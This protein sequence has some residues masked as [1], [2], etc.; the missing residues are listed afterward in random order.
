MERWDDI[1]FRNRNT[2]YGAYAHRK[3]YSKGVITG[4][5]IVVL[6][7]V[8]ISIWALY[9]YTD[10]TSYA[11]GGTSQYEVKMNT[12]P[13]QP[14]PNKLLIPQTGGSPKK[15][16][17]NVQPVVAKDPERDFDLTQ[18][19]T[20]QPKGDTAGTGN[21]NRNNGNGNGQSEESGDGP[22]PV[23]VKVEEPPQFPGGEKERNLFLQRNVKYPLLARQYK[24]QGTVYA[25]F[26]IEKSGKISNIKILQGIGCGCDDEVSRV[27]HMMPDWIP[28]KNNG[29]PVRVQMLMPVSFFLTVQD[30]SS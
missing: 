25:T 12:P 26:I 17:E 15:K 21:G 29:Q 3:D 4:I 13:A 27:V 10:E 8:A 24:V 11:S 30:G 2:E 22:A 18:N 16:I 5:L 9:S 6:V 14:N 19:D 1:I 20:D 23:Y 7:A 28:G